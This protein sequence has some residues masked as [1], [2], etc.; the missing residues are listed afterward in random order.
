VASAGQK[1][2]EGRFEEGSNLL[3]GERFLPVRKAIG[4]FL[5]AARARLGLPLAKVASDV[6]IV[7]NIVRAAEAPDGSGYSQYHV[8]LSTVWKL[9]QYYKLR[10][11]DVVPIL[12]MYASE[13]ST[14]A[15]ASLGHLEA[16]FV[17]ISDDPFLQAKRFFDLL[18]PSDQEIVLSDIYKRAFELAPSVST[19]KEAWSRYKHFSDR[20]T[21][22]MYARYGKAKRRKDEETCSEDSK[23]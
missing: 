18:S 3:L 5:E 4:I 2:D 13:Q 1:Y 11:S 15:Q 21:D 23:D 12:D 7:R 17:Q 10:F 9:F 16:A 20:V 14:G 6:G 8:E 22:R 19:E